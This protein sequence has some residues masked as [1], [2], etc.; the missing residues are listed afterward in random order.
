M[1]GICS[2]QFRPT[3][4][5]LEAWKKV[6]SIVLVATGDDARLPA[7][8][9]AVGFWNALFA[10]LGSPFRFGPITRTTE[11]ITYDD[12]R[13]YDSDIDELRLLYDWSTGSF[14]LR[15][16]VRQLNGDIVVVLS[17]AAKK[18]FALDYQ[19]R[20]KVLIVIEGLSKYPITQSNAVQNTI[21]HELGH[22]IGLDHNSEP[23]ALMCGGSARC[24]YAK[25]HE[26]F[27][28]LTKAER[29]MLLRMYPPG[30]QE[31]PSRR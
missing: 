5:A 4:S 16:R 25:V 22:A 27:L 19:P 17:N 10:N 23:A 11:M 13:P 7:V 18:S 9:E 31:E 26:S 1:P 24:S 28:P 2:A 30:W 20:R 12:T 3:S 8:H 15:E 14:N 29:A 6:P 21:A